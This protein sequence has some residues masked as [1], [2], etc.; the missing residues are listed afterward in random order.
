MP[1]IK[2]DLKS[3]IDKNQQRLID[4]FID[5]YS[6]NTL[7]AINLDDH[8]VKVVGAST[9]FGLIEMTFQ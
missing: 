7:E 2:E 6:F 8:L 1:A 3:S 5:P 4:R 9:K